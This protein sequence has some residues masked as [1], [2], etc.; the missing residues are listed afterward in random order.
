MTYRV[1]NVTI[2][3]ALALVAALLTLFSTSRTTPL[4]VGAARAGDRVGQIYVAACTTSPPGPRQAGPTPFE[5]ARVQRRPRSAEAQRRPGRD[6]GS[7]PGGESLAVSQ[8][9]LH[10]RAGDGAALLRRAGR[11][12]RRPAEGDHAGDRGARRCEPAARRNSEGRRSRRPG[13]QP[14]HRPQYLTRT[15]R[16]VLRDLAVH[17][18]LRRAR[19]PSRRPRR[20]SRPRSSWPSR[21]PRSSASSMS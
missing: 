13:R 3:I 14:A 18:R 8:H 17:R 11:G 1:R 12:D 2:A 9:D 7:E 6:L 15:T 19:H 4:A 5:Q 20:A 21:T 16:I 10:G